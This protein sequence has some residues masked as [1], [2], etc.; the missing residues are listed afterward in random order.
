MV[1]TFGFILNLVDFKLE[2]P[3]AITDEFSIARAD[4]VQRGKIQ[5]YIASYL[6]RERAYNPYE[7]EVIKRINGGTRIPIDNPQDYNYWVVNTSYKWSIIDE[8]F[9]DESPEEAN[10][11]YLLQ[12]AFNLSSTSFRIGYYYNEDVPIH[13]RLVI[14]T[15][16]SNN[17]FFFEQNNWDLPETVNEDQLIEIKEIY[18]LL[19]NMDRETKSITRALKELD[20]L[21]YLPPHSKLKTLGYFAI[22][23]SILTHNPNTTDSGDSISRQLKAKIPLLN[24]RFARSIDF[25]DS[26]GNESVE[27]VIAKLYSYRSKIAHGAT[28]NFESGQLQ[29]LKSHK[30]TQNFIKQLTKKIIIHALTEPQLV[31]DLQK[32]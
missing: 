32:C 15:F 21:E 25:S 14:D 26:F 17:R 7:Y 4:E 28:V 5:D 12:D 30:D 2:L 10:K 8:M 3:F 29:S 9:E 11:V 31:I 19:R 1:G 27:K 16:L 23:E 24:N 20:E 22:I 13:L 18:I 6:P